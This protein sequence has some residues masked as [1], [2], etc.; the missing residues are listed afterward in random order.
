MSYNA[1]KCEFFVGSSI[2]VVE[3]TKNVV[4]KECDSAKWWQFLFKM[5]CRAIVWA[6]KLI[7]IKI[8]PIMYEAKETDQRLKWL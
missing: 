3:A 6:C 8:A 5:K 2:V 7:L 1:R 4:T